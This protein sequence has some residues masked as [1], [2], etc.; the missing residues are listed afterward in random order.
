MRHET[1]SLGTRVFG[2]DIDLPLIFSAVGSLRNAHRDGELAVTRTASAYG[3]IQFVSGVST[4]A[5]EDIVAQASGPV[6]AQ[7]YYIGGREATAPI[8]E[9]VRD[10]GVAGL[11]LI[12]DSASPAVGADVPYRKRYTYPQTRGLRELAGFVPQDVVRPAWTKDFLSANGLRLPIA[13]NS[14]G[15]GG[16]PLD[17][18]EVATRV[19]QETPDLADLP[20]IRNIWDGQILLKGVVTPESAHRAVDAGVDG[21][22]VSNHGGKRARRHDPYAA[23]PSGRGRRGGRPGRVDVILDGGVRRGTDVVKAL[24]LGAKAVSIGRAYSYALMAAGEPG[25]QRINEVPRTETDAA[26]A[27][28]AVSSVDELARTDLL[29]ILASSATITADELVGAGK[30]RRQGVTDRQ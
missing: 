13:A 9:R 6:Y 17:V 20:W 24:A 11:V 14:Y 12:A 19:Y 5:I 3:T 23:C 7:I 21:L 30:V 27:W 2:H 25:G 10:A 28:L 29:E 16:R 22:V 26:P 8:I 15:L 1:R 4:T 18:V